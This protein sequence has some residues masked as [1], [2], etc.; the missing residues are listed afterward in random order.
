M[1]VLL[2]VLPSRTRRSEVKNLVF[3]HVDVLA[4]L[5]YA[6]SDNGCF[7]FRSGIYQEVVSVCQRALCERFYVLPT[8]QS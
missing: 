7:P 2:L 6:L 5:R 1:N 8:L 3:I 4:T